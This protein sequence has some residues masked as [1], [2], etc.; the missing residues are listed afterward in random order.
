MQMAETGVRYAAGVLGARGSCWRER[1]GSVSG[2]FKAC[3]VTGVR[4]LSTGR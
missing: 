3:S 4:I 2:I 1:S